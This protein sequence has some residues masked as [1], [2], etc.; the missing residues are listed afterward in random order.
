MAADAVPM[1]TLQAKEV[2]SAVVP[3]KNRRFLALSDMVISFCLFTLMGIVTL[4]RS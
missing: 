1:P 2:R 4:Q 3:S